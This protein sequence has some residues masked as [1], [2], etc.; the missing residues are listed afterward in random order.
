LGTNG[1]V[2]NKAV[3]K[4]LTEAVFLRVDFVVESHRRPRRSRAAGLSPLS[5]QIG[6][7]CDAGFAAG[8]ARA[9]RWLPMSFGWA[10]HGALPPS[11][12]P[13]RGFAQL[14]DDF[15]RGGIEVGN[16]VRARMRFVG[17]LRRPDRNWAEPTED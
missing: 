10:G 8:N 11:K 3:V 14:P 4:R 12:T 15:D 1:G 13:P 7:R 17:E 6:W 2:T 5:I 16:V 9:A